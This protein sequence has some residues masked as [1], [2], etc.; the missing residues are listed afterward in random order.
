MF[1]DILKRGCKAEALPRRSLPLNVVMR[2]IVSFGDLRVCKGDSKPGVKTLR[3]GL[4]RHGLRRRH[5]ACQAGEICV[6]WSRFKTGGILKLP[7]AC[8]S[9]A[10]HLTE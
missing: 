6:K 7:L 3:I 1:F 10:T 4:Q 8:T 9:G 2:L 5:Q